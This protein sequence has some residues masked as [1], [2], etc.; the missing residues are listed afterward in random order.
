MSNGNYTGLETSLSPYAGP[1]VSEMLGRGA[2]LANL[3]YTAYQGPLTAGP[4]SLQSQA[5][6]GLASLGMPQASAAGSFSGAGYTPL[7]PTQL[8]E[9]AQPSFTP[10]SDNVVQQYMTPYLQSVLQPQYDAAIRDAEMAQQA[11]Q[12]QYSRAGAFGGGR[13][14]VA[15]AELGRGLLDRLAGITGQGYQQAY[16]DAQNMFGRD[17]DYGLQALRAQQVG[18]DTQRQID[19]QGILADIAQF[20]QERDFPYKQTQYMQSLLQ[21]L[22]ISTQAYQYSEPSTFNT[23]L[24]SAGGVLQLFEQLGF[25]GDKT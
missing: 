8:T 22:P 24:G 11:L 7:T 5:F 25:L 23:A 15:E 13:Q 4:S 16:T 1:Y 21:G 6:Q 3:P 14:A 2:A 10:A 19:Q 12:S 20:E 9:G 17:R 18:G